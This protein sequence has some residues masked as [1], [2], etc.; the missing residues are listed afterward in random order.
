MRGELVGH[1]V[2]VVQG[3]E[4]AMEDDQRLAVAAGLKVKRR[5]HIARPVSPHPG[6]L[7]RERE[8]QGTAF[9]ISN[10][11]RRAN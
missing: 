6:P 4:Q 5:L 7:P 9:E 2:P 1:R 8:Q 11:F 10:H 3:A